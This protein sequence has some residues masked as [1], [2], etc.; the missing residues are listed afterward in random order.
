MSDP[1]LRTSSLVSP[2]AVPATD[3]AVELARGALIAGTPGR[4]NEWSG[5]AKASTAGAPS[6]RWE[7]FFRSLG[8]AGWADLAA[9]RQRVQ[10]RVRDDGAS[11]NVYADQSARPWPIELLPLILDADEWAVIE[12]GV[13]QRAR[14]LEATLA[15][16]YGE[17]TLLRDALLPASLVFAHPQYLR[18]AHGLQP[19]GGTHLHIVAFDLARAP[20]GGFCVL[21]QRVQAPSGLGYLL[22]NRLITAPQL[23][24]SFND[25]N[26]QRVAA[27][28][29]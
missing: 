26:V 21:A 19:V 7:A 9:R 4:F 5:S 16:L 15:D 17:Q 28:F 18:A 29:R 12:H 1:L 6:A 13:L 27:S 14:L 8:E 23:Q 25:L 20:E 22:E 2:L 24:D 10:Q 3:P 11:Y